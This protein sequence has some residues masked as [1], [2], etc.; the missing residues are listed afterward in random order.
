MV[1][2]L[3]VPQLQG[4]LFANSGSGRWRWRK[5]ALA[6]TGLTISELEGCTYGRLRQRQRTI[7]TTSIFTK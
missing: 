1:V 4:Q 6:E 2:L 7:T 5:P 3:W